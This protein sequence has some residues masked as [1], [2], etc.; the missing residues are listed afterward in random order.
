MKGIYADAQEDIPT[1][2]PIPRG[3]SVQLNCFVDADHSFDRITRRSQTGIILFGNS[4]PLLWYSKRQKTVESS[5][6]G[7]EFVALRIATELITSFQYKLRMFGIP[8]DGPA[9]VFCDNEAVYQNSS[10]VESQLKQ[11][12]NLICY[13]LVREA[14]AAEKMVVFKIDRKENLADLLTKSVLGRRRKNMRSK[15]MFSEKE[16]R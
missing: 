7:S 5:T 12:H 13:H 9:N 8:L 1:N 6:F 2:A 3:K 15:I 4:A 11:K 16:Q 10:F 14:V